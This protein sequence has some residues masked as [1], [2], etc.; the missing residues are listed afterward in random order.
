MTTSMNIVE[1]AASHPAF[2]TLATALSAADL[3]FALGCT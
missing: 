3:T 1:T 2:L